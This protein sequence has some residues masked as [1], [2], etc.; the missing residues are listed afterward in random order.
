MN[1]IIKTPKLPQLIV[2]LAVGIMM[3]LTA[4]D[5]DRLAGCEGDIIV[6]NEIPDLTLYLEGESFI[7]DLVHE[8]PPV[9]RHTRDEKIVTTARAA[10]YMNTVRVLNRYNEEMNSRTILEIIPKGI[11]STV[12]EVVARDDCFDRRRTTTFTV[13][14]LDN[15][16]ENLTT[17]ISN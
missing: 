17:L 1:S 8:Q 13:T 10:D 3:T 5:Q 14:V 16:N 6:E 7:R 12:I 15:D 4:C 9:F 2:L 11:G